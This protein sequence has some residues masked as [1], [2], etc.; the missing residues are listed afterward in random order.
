MILCHRSRHSQQGADESGLLRPQPRLGLN[1]PRPSR[2]AQIV[3][4]HLNLEMLRHLLAV[5]VA[6]HHAVDRTPS[7]QRL[8]ELNS[9]TWMLDYLDACADNRGGPP[10]R[11]DPWLPWL[12]DEDRKQ[13]RRGPPSANTAPTVLLPWQPTGVSARHPQAG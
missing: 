7:A 4:P 5:D 11:L 2:P 13:E 3:I 12:M 10:E 8:A 9:Y 6:T 1:L